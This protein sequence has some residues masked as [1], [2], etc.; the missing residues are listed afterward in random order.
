MDKQI[1]TVYL[2]S[3]PHSLTIEMEEKDEN[4]VFKVYTDQAL[5][6]K[7]EVMPIE[8][9]LEGEFHDDPAIRAVEG[10]YI[11][12]TIWRNIEERF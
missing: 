11:A 7:I 5:Q 12:R 10:E 2:K 9:E 8:F 1:V 3:Y 6:E 4:T